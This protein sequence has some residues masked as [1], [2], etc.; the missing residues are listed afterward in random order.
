MSIFIH[1]RIRKRVCSGKY[2]LICSGY[3]FIIC[4]RYEICPPLPPIPSSPTYIMFRNWSSIIYLAL[5][6]RPGRYP[7]CTEN[8]HNDTRD[9]GSVISNPSLFCVFSLSSLVWGNQGKWI[10]APYTGTLISIQTIQTIAVQYLFT[11][12]ILGDQINIHSGFV[13]P[14][15]RLQV[16]SALFCS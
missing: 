1:M 7:K 14:S 10:I 11:K 13:S 5:Q 6:S 9:R 15:Q 4:K 16:A 12:S 3:L 2:I 8:V